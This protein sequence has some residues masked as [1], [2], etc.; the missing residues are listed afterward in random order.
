MLCRY[1]NEFDKKGVMRNEGSSDNN[2]GN[3]LIALFASVLAPLIS[4]L[5]NIVYGYQNNIWSTENIILVYLSSITGYILSTKL[6]LLTKSK[7]FTKLGWI[8]GNADTVRYAVWILPVILSL[9]TDQLL[10]NVLLIALT[11]GA[12]IFLSKDL[13]LIY[14][15]LKTLVIIGMLTIIFILMYSIYPYWKRYILFLVA[16]FFVAAVWDLIVQV[17]KKHLNSKG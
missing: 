5:F 4:R 17:R 1:N 9:N 16:S 2:V 10:V 12:I 11:L 15:D 7:M 3:L 8:F 6:Y 13:S 14:L